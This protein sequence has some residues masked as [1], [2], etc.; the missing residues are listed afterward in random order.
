MKTKG[1]TS[2]PDGAFNPSKTVLLIGNFLSSSTGIRSVCEDLAEHLSEKGWQI[3]STSN[4][5]K[6]LPRLFD[7]INTAWTFRRKYS[8]ALIDVYSG[9]A[10]LWAEAVA[11]ILH[12]LGKPFILTL[13]GGNMPAFAAGRQ[14]RVKRLL[15]LA[16]AVTTPSR[17][18]L[19]KMH[20]YRDDIILLPN[21][22]DLSAYKFRL[23]EYPSR[24]LLWLRSF[25]D[26]Y[27]PSLAI[28]VLQRL[29]NSFPEIK[30]IMVGP[31]K[32][33]GSLQSA[34]KTAKEL[35]IA[36]KIEI[37]GSVSKKEVPD[38]LDKC[39]IFI[40]TTNVDNT[41]VS[42]LE[43]M[44]SGLCVVSTD[45][46]GIPYLLSDEHDA[47]LVPPDDPAAMASAIQRILTEPGLAKRLSLNGRKK[48]EQ[49]D[50]SVIV[51]QFEK[52]IE[53]LSGAAE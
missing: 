32:G 50:W 44:A 24:S 15:R 43:A 17:Y 33:D 27:N 12:V 37:T 46:G 11:F 1:M 49:F 38:W 5:Q 9:S 41:P 4:K 28:R 16:A 19:E 10:F 48:V 8:V 39:C 34:M 18:L 47:L 23:R 20:I 6:R 2:S 40:N 31:D 52:L 3:I 30:L 14:R 26:I 29:K 22:L 7:M 13:H 25:H 42:V 53:Q 51:P 21:F 35:G 36:D 45:V